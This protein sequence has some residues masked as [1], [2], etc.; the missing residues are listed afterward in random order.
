MKGILLSLAGVILLALQLFSQQVYIPDSNFLNALIEQGVD[1]NRDGQID[2]EEAKEIKVLDVRQ[3]GI[4]KLTGIKAFV[5]LT[6]LD[7]GNIHWPARADIN[8]ISCLDVSGLV[9]LKRLYCTKSGIGSLNL[10]DCTALDTLFCDYN[11]LSSLDVSNNPELLWLFCYKSGLPC[12]DLS[13][14]T[15]LSLLACGGNQLSYLDI[16]N[17]PDLSYLNIREMSCLKEVCVAE[18]P[19]PSENVRVYMDGCPDSV[20]TAV[21]PDYKAPCILAE[22]IVYMPDNIEFTSSE[23]GV[24][25]LVPEKTEN[26]VGCIYGSCIDSVVVR[27]NCSAKISSSGLDEGI[28]WLYA[29][30]AAGNIS[31]PKIITLIGVGIQHNPSGPIRLYPN[32]TEN[33]LTIEVSFPDH[34]S[35]SIISMKGQEIYRGSME[36]S[37]HHIDF[38]PFREG[39]YFFTIRSKN[40]K[41]TEKI[42][43][44]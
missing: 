24:V 36:G 29:R 33:I 11:E 40:Y 3:K 10:S 32:P 18:L 26:Q 16:S 37:L 35:I 43:K 41:K 27:S 19:F 20:F 30:D 31:E 39:I 9:A 2:H 6:E 42:I 7:C 44:L 12:L 14:N 13:N 15:L 1:S 4:R 22:D 5:N 21:C 17:N 28:Y 23:D 34:Y 8:K 25:Y 38:S